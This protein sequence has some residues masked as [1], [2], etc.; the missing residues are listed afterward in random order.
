MVPGT[1]EARTGHIEEGEVIMGKPSDYSNE[2]RQLA[3][4]VGY[5]EQ[6]QGPSG[7]SSGDDE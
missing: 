5:P 6:P 4:S 1:E 2:E 3:E 7:S